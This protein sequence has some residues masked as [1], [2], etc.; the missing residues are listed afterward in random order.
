[1]GAIILDN[2]IIPDDSLVAGSL[3]APGKT[4]ESGYLI[5]G[6]PARALLN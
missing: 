6:S 2:A 3:T 5:V 4:F 1:M